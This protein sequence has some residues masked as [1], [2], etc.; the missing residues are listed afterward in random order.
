MQDWGRELAEL[1]RR[2]HN[3]VYESDAAREQWRRKVDAR[4]TALTGDNGTEL[5]ASGEPTPEGAPA[6]YREVMARFDNGELDLLTVIS[7]DTEDDDA[8]A[9]SMWM[10]ARLMQAKA[11]IGLLE[12]GASLDDAY[13]QAITASDGAGRR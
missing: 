1:R 6:G 9:M 10:D 2:L 13:A 4:L 3:V 5:A 7:G 8:R 12:R 11:I